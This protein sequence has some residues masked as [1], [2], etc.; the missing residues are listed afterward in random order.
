MKVFFATAVKR[1][2]DIGLVRCQKIVE[3][4]NSSRK[5]KRGLYI[6]SSFE[7][8]GTFNRTEPVA[9]LLLGVLVEMVMSHTLRPFWL[10]LTYR[11][12]TLCNFVRLP[13]CSILLVQ[14]FKAQ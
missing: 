11:D 3:S 12:F 2:G 1:F 7:S 5:F 9:S 13:R 6:D 10:C 14:H 8:T 4:T